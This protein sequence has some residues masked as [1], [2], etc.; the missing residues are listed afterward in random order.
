MGL[1]GVSLLPKPREFFNNVAIDVRRIFPHW[2]W[3]LIACGLF[4]FLIVGIRS[5]NFLVFQVPVWIL[6]LIIFTFAI[7][8]WDV[9]RRVDLS[10]HLERSDWLWMIGLMI[11]AILAGVYRLQGL[12]CRSLSLL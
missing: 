2:R 5:E 8:A 3:L 7:A 9:D 11:A 6:S 12:P 4:I 10:P 1:Q